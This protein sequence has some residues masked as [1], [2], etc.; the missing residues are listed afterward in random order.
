VERFD[1][2]AGITGPAQIVG[3]HSLSPKERIYIERLYSSLYNN[4]NANLIFCDAYIIYRTCILLLT[5]KNLSYPDCIKFLLLHGAN[6]EISP[7]T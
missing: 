3:K 4:P 2:P 6:R 7:N 1:S 5:G